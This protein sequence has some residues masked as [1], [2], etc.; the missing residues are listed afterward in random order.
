[1]RIGAAPTQVTTHSGFDF[2]QR[3]F[4]RVHFDIGDEK[5]LAPLSSIG[6]VTGPIWVRSAIWTLGFLGSSKM[7]PIFE[8]AR[9]KKDRVPKNLEETKFETPDLQEIKPTFPSPPTSAFGEK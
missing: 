7:R 6:W 5:G 4:G 9:K 1:M 3:W 8:I 2:R